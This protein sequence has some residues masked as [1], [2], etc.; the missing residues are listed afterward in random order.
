MLILVA[1]DGS[2]SASRAV[3]YAAEVANKLGAHLKII[4]VIEPWPAPD[5]VIDNKLWT[6]DLR[7]RRLWERSTSILDVARKK[8]TEAGSR[9]SRSD[10]PSET[11]RPLLSK[12]PPKTG[13]S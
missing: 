3:I 12:R 7:G 5:P 10:R 8:A 11:R 1:A 6:S 2:G 9:M 4:N 13:R